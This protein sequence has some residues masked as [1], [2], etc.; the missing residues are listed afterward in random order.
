MFEKTPL[1]SIELN[2]M[3][4][5]K[6]STHVTGMKIPNVIAFAVELYE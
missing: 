2:K 6:R 3:R 5:V 4:L 1:S